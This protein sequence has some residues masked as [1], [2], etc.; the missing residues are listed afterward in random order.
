MNVNLENNNEI[1]KVEEILDKCLR[2]SS[3]IEKYYIKKP[4][5]LSEFLI[6]L[7]ILENQIHSILVLISKTKKIK[8]YYRSKNK[9]IPNF[10]EYTLG[11]WE[12][13]LNNQNLFDKKN[14]NKFINIKHFSKFRDIRN[15]VH[16]KLLKCPPVFLNEE[17]LINKLREVIE[18][19]EYLKKGLERMYFDLSGI[20]IN[21]VTGISPND[22]DYRELM[23][24]KI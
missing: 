15:R 23:K 8:N 2:F 24:N 17:E 20:K 13:F 9:E 7:I 10:Y 4:K 14:I 6:N 16:H 3:L 5:E 18:F 11:K 22:L 19:G 12:R 21:P 1:K